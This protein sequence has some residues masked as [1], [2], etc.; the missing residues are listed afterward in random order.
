MK[1]QAEVREMLAQMEKA[2]ERSA[3]AQKFREQDSSVP[4]EL[5][6]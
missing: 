1:K 4:R 5:R 6:G 3:A 2:A